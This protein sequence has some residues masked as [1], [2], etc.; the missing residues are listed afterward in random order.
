[1]VSNTLSVSW[2]CM[3]SRRG[4][5]VTSGILAFVGCTGPDDSPDI[6]IRYQISEFLNHDEVP[7]GI[8]EHPNPSGF[9][10]IAVT[11]TVQ[12][13]EFDASDI[14]GLTQVQVGDLL[15]PTRAVIVGEA[16]IRSGDSHTL[17]AG[18]EA[19]AYYRFE[20]GVEGDPSWELEQFENQHDNVDAQSA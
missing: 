2:L 13:G 10:W 4:L 1:M 6:E 5:L 20:D 8:V 7:D 11:F 15:E 14:V 12:S 19:T 17:A 16:V 9:Q 3:L 18:D